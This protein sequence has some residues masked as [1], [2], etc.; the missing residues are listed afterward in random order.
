MNSA[1]NEKKPGNSCPLL[2][3]NSCTPMACRCVSVDMLLCHS[4]IRA[5][6]RGAK[7]ATD[8][9]NAKLKEKQAKAEAAEVKHGEWIKHKPDP[10]AIKKWHALGIAKGMSENSIFWTCSCCKEWGTP[11][12]KY[13]SQCGAKMD[14][15]DLPG[16]K[17]LQKMLKQLEGG[18]EE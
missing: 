7:A 11:A 3:N 9:I 2:L 6:N 16:S 18:A 14:G 17:K 8:A 1:E 4:L 12:H 13:C 5:Y 10:E 15:E